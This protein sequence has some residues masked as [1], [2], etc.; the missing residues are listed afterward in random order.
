MS[1]LEEPLYLRLWSRPSWEEGA[2]AEAHWHKEGGLPV[3]RL[4]VEGKGPRAWQLLTALGKA[5]EASL[6]AARPEAVILGTARGESLALLEAF[7]GSQQGGPLSPTLS[8]DTSGGTLAS[9]FARELG[10]SGPAWVVSQTCLSGLLALYQAA[11]LIRAQEA[12]TVLFGAVEAP[13]HPFFVR[14][15]AA[16][17]LYTPHKRY[18]FVRPGDRERK[19]TFALAEGVALGL[20]SRL[21]VGPFQ[22]MALRVAT[23]APRKGIAFTAVD[24][25]ALANLLRSLGET[26]PDVVL[27]HA[28]GTQQGDAAEWQ[29]I[30]SVWGALPALSV[31]ALFGHSLGAAPLVSLGFL[32]EVLQRQV[33]PELPYAPLWGKNPPSRWREAV[34]IGLGYGGSMGALRIQYVP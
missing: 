1:R 25:D 4:P 28:P 29:A 7:A 18:P 6:R 12:T 21:P 14:M 26:P 32:L 13:L 8:P 31:K 3:Y 33:W 19:N 30:Q 27:L 24:P 11:L 34:L 2:H 23:A 5:T 17:R 10:V 20:L 22:L 15:M 9:R 16:L